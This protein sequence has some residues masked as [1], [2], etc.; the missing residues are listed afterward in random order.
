RFRV[1][2]TLVISDNLKIRTQIDLLDNLVLGSTPGGY[3]NVPSANGYAVA[4]RD[5]FEPVSGL[6]YTQSPPRSGINSLQDS[7]LVKRAWAEYTTP[8]GQLR[9]GRMPDHWGL[10]ILHN[11]GDDF[12]GDYQSTVDRIAFFTALPSLSLHVGGAWD[13][14]AEGPTSEPFT[15]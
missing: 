14:A 3:A 5:N 6:T 1:E 10:G 4:P 15:P 8:V 11:A 7:I 12:D 13:F 2:P 9:F